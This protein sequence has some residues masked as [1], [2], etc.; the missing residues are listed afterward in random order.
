MANSKKSYGEA[1]EKYIESR[2][3]Q[4]DDALK[5]KWA[6]MRKE[7][8]LFHNSLGKLGDREL[9][10]LS[11]SLLDD[12]LE[13][14]ITEAYIKDEKV[15]SIFKDD[16]VLQSF[17][18]K[19]N[20]AY[21]SG[22]IPKWLFNDLKLICEIRN[23]F[24]HKFIVK[25]DLIDEAITRKIDKCELRP[26]T[27]D[28]VKSPRLK[29]IIVTTLAAASLKSINA[30]LIHNKPQNLMDIYRM[31]EWDYEEMALTKDEIIEIAAKTSG[32]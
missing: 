16:H 25:L 23:K 29:F 3:K 19:I 2:L 20:V 14:I 6:E 18:T 17:Y 9:V 27:L 32:G 15:K 30:M 1:I 4:L 8:E 22:L 24:A 7:L 21:F 10:I 26:K 5:F 11:A 28:S 31:N 13:A 12:Y